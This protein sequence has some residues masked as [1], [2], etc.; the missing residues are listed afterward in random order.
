L[1]RKQV[2]AM[3]WHLMDEPTAANHVAYADVTPTARYAAALDWATAQGLVAAFG[4]GSFRPTDRV[5]RSQLVAMLWRTAGA[6]TGSAPHGYTDTRLGAYYQ[7]A[8]DWAVDH[9]LIEPVG[10]RRFR[11]KEPV[12]RGATVTWMYHLAWTADAWSA[13]PA[14]PDAVLF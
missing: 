12:T 2:V 10:G 14:L 1:K 11:P 6:P 7:P 3:L 13:A 5:T 8:L 9:G 4:D